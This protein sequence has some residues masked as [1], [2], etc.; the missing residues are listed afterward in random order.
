[1]GLETLPCASTATLYHQPLSGAH[2]SLP[3]GTCPSSSPALTGLRGHGI[4]CRAGRSRAGSVVGP[5]GYVVLCVG[6]QAGDL[7]TGV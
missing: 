3:R 6:V 5:H 2:P 7:G 1:M 4:G